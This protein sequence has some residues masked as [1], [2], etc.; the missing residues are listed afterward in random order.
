MQA[1]DF[2]VKLMRH[3]FVATLARKYN[4]DLEDARQEAF[5]VAAELAHKFDPNRGA[6]LET[7][8]F[9]HL[10]RRLQRQAPLCAAEFD[11]N[12][13][14]TC[15]DEEQDHHLGD[16]EI[17]I[18]IA[19]SWSFMHFKVADLALQSLSTNEIA[20]ELNVTPRRVRQIVSELSSITE[21]DN[22][23]LSLF[24]GEGAA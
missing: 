10:R 7:F 9:S 5:L 11:E 8:L 14:V 19:A 23:Q 15:A 1:V 4:L 24:G 16:E 13:E 22:G 17:I 2:A 20:G 3:P 6:T 18:K 12:K 21:K